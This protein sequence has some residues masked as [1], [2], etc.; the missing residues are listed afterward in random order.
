MFAMDIPE[1]L[2]APMNPCFLTGGA[3]PGRP[4]TLAPATPATP[5]APGVTIAIAISSPLHFPSPLSHPH[6][7]FLLAPLFNPPIYYN[8][9]ITSLT[10]E[11]PEKRKGIFSNKYC[12]RSKPVAVSLPLHPR[13]LAMDCSV[14]RPSLTHGLSTPCTLYTLY[15]HLH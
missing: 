9:S 5:I 3:N 7:N 12:F 1:E 6:S 2:R 4:A 8:T 15:R 14:L 11:A 10:H 13:L